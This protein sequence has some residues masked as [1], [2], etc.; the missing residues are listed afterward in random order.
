MAPFPHAY[1]CAHPSIMLGRLKDKSPDAHRSD[2]SWGT[3]LTTVWKRSGVRLPMLP[4]G[5]GFPGV[6]ICMNVSCRPSGPI[7]KVF[8]NWNRPLKKSHPILPHLNFKRLNRARDAPTCLGIEM[9]VKWIDSLESQV[10]HKFVRQ[11][12]V[13]SKDGNQGALISL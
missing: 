7:S 13:V 12:P 3:W 5:S 9:R 2:G 6:W 8:R 11:Y 10:V 4:F 1:I